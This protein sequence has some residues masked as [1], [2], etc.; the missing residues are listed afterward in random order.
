M[1][2]RWKHPNHKNRHEQMLVRCALVAYAMNHGV[3]SAAR[4]FDCSIPTVYQWLYK[5]KQEPNYY[6]VI[7]LIAQHRDYET[8]V[9]FE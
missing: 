5:M 8:Y 4:K 9:I 7:C 3:A 6:P 1:A 2:V